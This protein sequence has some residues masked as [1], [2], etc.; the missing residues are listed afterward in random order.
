MKDRDW[1]SNFLNLVVLS[2]KTRWPFNRFITFKKN[3]MTV[4][5]SIDADD[6]ESVEEI[7]D[8]LNKNNDLELDKQ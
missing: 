2:K 1:I 6:S 3:V 4:G 7:L 8:E 5:E